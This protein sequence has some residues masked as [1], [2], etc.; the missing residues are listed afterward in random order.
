MKKV[1]A[2]LLAITMLSALFV[3]GTTV[4]AEENYIVTYSAEE[5]TDIDTIILLATAQRTADATAFS[6]AEPTAVTGDDDEPEQLTY[7]QL[8]EV[9]EYADGSQ[10]EVYVTNSVV[11]PYVAEGSKTANGYSIAVSFY[12]SIKLEDGQTIADPF[13]IKATKVVGTIVRY[14]TPTK[15]INTVRL[16]YYR[17]FGGTPVQY[18]T[19]YNY[20]NGQATST[21]TFTMTASDTSYYRIEAA[22]DYLSWDAQI[23]VTYADST[24]TA[25]QASVYV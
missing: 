24:Y 25:A 3:S 12:Y 10:E 5:I 16:E 9:R 4:S 8:L 18:A 2:I 23:I 11:Q 17:T 13:Y 21:Q 1:I 19:Y 7:N 20:S 6:L 15:N 22:A 14:T